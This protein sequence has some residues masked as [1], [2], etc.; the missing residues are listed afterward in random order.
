MGDFTLSGPKD[1]HTQFWKDLRE[2]IE[3]EPPTE[4]GRVLGRDHLTEQIDGKTVVTFDMSEYAQQACDMY[5][6]LPGAKPFKAVAAPFLSDG[7]LP[8]ADSTSK[9]ELAS[10][11][12]SVLLKLLWLGRLSKPEVILAIG[13]L[14]SKVQEWS[15]R[16]DRALYR[17][18]CYV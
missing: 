16:E 6:A 2:H 14:A 15:L 8:L 5:Q 12:C 9:G 7:S 17:L 4:L 3:L 10:K 1:K 11:A 13:L 18:M